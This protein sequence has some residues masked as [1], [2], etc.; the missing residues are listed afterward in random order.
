MN[1]DEVLRMKRGG[2]ACADP[3]DA[4]TTVFIKNDDRLYANKPTGFE[5]LTS[6]A[7]R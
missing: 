5:A 3:D 1:C 6:R 2:A 7:H 4:V